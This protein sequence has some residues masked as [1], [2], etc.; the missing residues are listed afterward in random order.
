MGDTQH[1]PTKPCPLCGEAILAI[2]IKCRHCGS[3]LESASPPVAEVEPTALAVGGRSRFKRRW[4]VLGGAVFALVVGALLASKLSL[5]SSPFE[6]DGVHVGDDLEAAKAKWGMEPE[7][8]QP[9]TIVEG[10]TGYVWRRPEA[11][12]KFVVVQTEANSNRIVEIVADSAED[13]VSVSIRMNRAFG[14]HD[15]SSSFNGQRRT[16]WKRGSHSLS[17]RC[18]KDGRSALE[19]M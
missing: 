2:A 7:S 10:R 18:L 11:A 17:V 15:S 14:P 1:E 9:G 8:S 6:V 12:L 13:C 5:A 4:A 16:E 19:A 3:M